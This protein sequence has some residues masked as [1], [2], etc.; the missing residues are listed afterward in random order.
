M[1]QQKLS[2]IKVRL[3]I[4]NVG[5]ENFREIILTLFKSFFI[6]KKNHTL[7][8]LSIL[9]KIYIYNHY[10]NNNVIIVNTRK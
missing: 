7:N 6:K 1:F 10:Q 8:K 3:K 4:I 2:I 9:C 5:L